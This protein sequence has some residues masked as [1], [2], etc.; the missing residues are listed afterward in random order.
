MNILFLCGLFPPDRKQEI[1][2]NSKGVIQNAANNLQW[3][4]V[5]GFEIYSKKIN[6]LTLPFIGS[7]P[8]GYKKIYFNRSTFYHKVGRSVE[9]VGFITFPLFNL[10]N[11]YINSKHELLKWSSNTE[12]TIW[13]IIYSIHTPFLK[14]AIDVKKKNT[15]IKICLIVPDLPQFTTNNKNLIYRFLKKIDSI[16]IKKLLEKVNSFVLLSDYMV[17][18]LN[19]GT[20]PWVRIEGIFKPSLIIR[21]VI[22]EKKKTIFYSGT[23]A[24]HYGILNLLQA[25]IK[26]ENKDYQ[27]WI[28]G[29]GN[30]KSEIIKI[31][32]IDKRIRYFGQIPHEEV[33][34]LQSR[35]T[36][37]VNPRTSQGEFTKYSFP[38]KTMEYL[39]SG[40]PCIINRLK[41]IPNEYFDY[42]FVP[43]DESLPALI[44]TIIE[45]CSKE[46]SELNDLGIRA[47]KFINEK[48][49]P[50]V[51]CEKIYKMLESI[52]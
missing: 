38:S 16:I 9:S 47:K 28:C 1:L 50:K 3:Y 6:V 43:K 13:I 30:T 19:I 26:I 27:L 25:F 32:E 10:F 39:A 23:L 4:M 35:A 15:K 5:E 48:K 49:S 11:R 33:L 42:C 31:S 52:K 51:Q 46:Q 17:K 24:S 37:L 12:E 44:E 21:P 29:E 20:K 36:V 41:G 8:F 22:K 45:V 18:E 14:A 7:F 40:T 2:K 34:K